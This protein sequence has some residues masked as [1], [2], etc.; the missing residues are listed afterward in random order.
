M[1]SSVIGDNGNGELLEYRHLVA[2][3]KTR[4]TWT[5]SYGNEIGRLAQGMPGR[6][7]GTNTIVFIKKDQ[8]P[9]TRAKDVTYSLITTLIRPEKKGEPNRTRLVAGGDRVHYPGD[10][11]TPTTTTDLLTVTILLNSTISTP[12]VK[13]MT[14]DI[15]DFYLNIPMA[16][17]EYMRLCLSDTTQGRHRTLQAQRNRD[18]RRIHLLRNPKGNVWLTTGRDHCPATSRRAPAKG[19]LP[20]EQNHTRLVDARKPLDQFLPRR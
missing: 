18:T 9:R 8:V 7:T 1:A 20:P 12:N 3:P 2:N 13:F 5:H 6:N 17:Y 16:R 10:A 19:R 15:K 14:M 4:S 11:G